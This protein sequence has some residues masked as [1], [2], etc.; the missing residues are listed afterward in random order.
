MWR[1]EFL[2]VYRIANFIKR[3][4]AY[5]DPEIERMGAPYRHA[6]RVKVVARDGRTFEKMLLDRRGSPEKPPLIA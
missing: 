3:I 1:E 6:A 4:R 5:V 2:C